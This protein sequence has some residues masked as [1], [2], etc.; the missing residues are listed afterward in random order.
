MSRMHPLATPLVGNIG[1]VP[2]LTP[3]CSARRVEP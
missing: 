2:G 1:P 3:F